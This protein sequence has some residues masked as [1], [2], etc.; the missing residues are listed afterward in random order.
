MTAN[1][2]AKP[3]PRRRPSQAHRTRESA[4]KF[5]PPVGAPSDTTIPF[6][7]VG[8]GNGDVLPAIPSPTIGVG[9][10][11]IEDTPN[12]LD[13]MVHAAMG[14][15]TFS[16]SPISLV[17]A[18]LDWMFHL[19]GSPGKQQALVEKALRKAIRFAVY[20]TRTMAEPDLPPCIEPLP[21]DHRFTDPSWLQLPFRFTYQWFLL[22]QQWWHNATTGVNGVSH[23][24]QEV[25]SFVARQLLDTM[26]PSNFIWANPQLLKCTLEMGGIN[27]VHG[28]VNAIEDWERAI[29]GKPP[30]GS[31]RFRP[32][33]Q[34]AVTPGQIVYRNRLM[35]LIQYSPAKTHV[36]AEPILIVPAW[37]MKYYILDLSPRNSLVRY[38][39]ERG[40]SVFMISWRNPRAEDRDLGIEDYLRLGVLEAVHA[41][42]TIVPG[43]PINAAG[44]CIGGT[45]LSIAAALL[46]RGG[47]PPL[48]SVTLLAAQVDFT[49]AG[50]LTL[51]VDESQLAYL[52]DVMWNQGYLDTKQMAGAFQLLR[53]N[54]LVWSRLIHD[55]L[56]GERQPMSD[57][58]AWNAD[59]TRMPYRMHS[60]YLHR[61]FLHNDLVEGR[62]EIAGRPV[63]LTDIRVP[64]F[65]VATEWDHV[66]PWHSVY[67]V[68][69]LLDTEVTFLL[70]NG[71]HNAGIVSEPGRAGRHFRIARHAVADRY[72]DPE[73]WF[74]SNLAIEGSWWPKWAEWLESHSKG[75]I[76]ALR[77]GA[78][79][80]GYPP[81]GPA[82]GSYVNEA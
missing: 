49:E 46:A 47:L 32:G 29:A 27:L 78:P 41:I 14:R 19:A 52:D 60:E 40:H 71:G 67:K 5:A 38:L 48:N 70:T 62:Y 2:I 58:V 16:V 8:R 21:Q 1:R 12:S 35:E 39:V 61:L 37:I 11:G 15:A 33:R 20:S 24:H 44:Y 68:N 34:V 72:I 4:A 57:L 73:T 45:L 28:A 3:S 69:F 56:M 42:R 80:E 53:S 74:A 66:A 25:V 75:K 82:P 18:Y 55:Y 13:R 30:V 81:L 10:T 36:Y 59:A 76:P 54:D 26:S 43:Q 6:V 64:V 17:L 51:F 7:D 9:D 77:I 23:H 63:A 22:I 31:E 79:Q 65:S 50:E